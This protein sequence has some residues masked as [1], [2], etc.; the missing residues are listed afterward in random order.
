MVNKVVPL[1]TMK[2]YGGGRSI[3]PLIRN[4]GNIWRW[5]VDK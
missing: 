3:A 2:V 1:H 5:V 4:I